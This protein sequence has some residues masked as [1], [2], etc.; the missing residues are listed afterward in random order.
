MGT[1][2]GKHMAATMIGG[3]GIVMAVNFTMASYATSGFSGVVVKNSY[4]AS[5]KY[6][7]WLDEAERQEATGWQI[8]ASRSTDGA[9][10]V[11]TPG[12]PPTATLS[13]I[14]RRPLGEHEVAAL[15]F[16]RTNAGDFIS[17]APLPEGRW[18]LRL[19]LEDG[20]DKR[21]VETA[22]E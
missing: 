7:A 11:N 4:V 8:D 13:G 3:F 14:A 21:T 19:T 12:A 2:T 5:Q 1:F 20:P 17:L 18:T 22:I 10:T 9:L 15:E 6:N 16:E